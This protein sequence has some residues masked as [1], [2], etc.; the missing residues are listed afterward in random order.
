MAGS[1]IAWGSALA[2][3][4]ATLRSTYA[5]GALR[6]ANS[7][8]FGSD[9]VLVDYAAAHL[10][11]LA[12]LVAIGAAAVVLATLYLLLHRAALAL[13]S[14]AESPRRAGVER[15]LFDCFVA[16]FWLTMVALLASP[17]VFAGVWLDRFF[18]EHLSL[19]VPGRTTCAGAS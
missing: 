8:R 19:P 5:P 18:V 16:L 4:H 13:R 11:L 3:L 1:L 2:G 9:P 6:L 15:F 17:L 14:L 10:N 12:T 7:E